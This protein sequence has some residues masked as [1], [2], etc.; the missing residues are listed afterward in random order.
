[1]ISKA[2]HSLI[3]G[4]DADER[5]SALED[6][7][8]FFWVDFNEDDDQIPGLCEAVLKTGNLSAEWDGDDLFFARGATRVPVALTRSVL[9]SLAASPV[10][11]F[12]D[13]V[14]PFSIANMLAWPSR[15]DRQTTLLTLNH[16]LDPDYEIRYVLGSADDNS[17]AFAPLSKSDWIALEQQHDRAAVDA[18]F[19]PIREQ[20]NFFTGG[21]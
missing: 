21:Y 1:M 2:I 3:R 10:T 16:V 14:L 20:P 18:A 8:A 5:R 17:V 11:A 12:V 7:S 19:S 4:G 15:G 13:S 9:A 6:A